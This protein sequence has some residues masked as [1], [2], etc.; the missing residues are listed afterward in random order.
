MIQIQSKARGATN[1]V[2]NNLDN[3]V[4]KMMK[5]VTESVNEGGAKSKLSPSEMKPIKM[6]NYQINFGKIARKAGG[7]RIR[8]NNN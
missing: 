8:N 6:S 5:T 4:A 1:Q 7:R 2:N 3:Y